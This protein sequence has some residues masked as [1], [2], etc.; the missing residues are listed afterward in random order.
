MSCWGGAGAP[1]CRRADVDPCR[2]LAPCVEMRVGTPGTPDWRSEFESHDPLAGVHASAA[3]TGYPGAT[4]ESNPVKRSL[5]HPAVPLIDLFA[6]PGGLCEGFSPLNGSAP[7]RFRSVLSIEM[8]ETAHRTLQLRAFLRRFAPRPIP[9]AYYQYLREE[10]SLEDLYLA[11]PAEAEAASRDAWRAEL[12][13]VPAKHVRRRIAHA[14]GGSENWV[15]LGGPPCQPFS[16]AGR[17]RNRSGTRYSDGQETRHRLYLEYLQI[18]ADFWPPV[19]VMENVRGLLSASY[20]GRRMFTRIQE[21]LRDPVRAISRENGRGLR[22]SGRSHTYELYPIS[23]PSADSLIGDGDFVV[24]CEDHGVPQARHRII[25]LG[26]RND[27]GVRPKHLLPDEPVPLRTVLDAM[28]RLRSGLS[29]G[30]EP[31]AWVSVVSS[32]R[33]QPWLRRLSDSDPAVAS[34]IVKA[35]SRIEASTLTRGA[36]FVALTRHIKGHSLGQW[37]EDPRLDGVPNHS[38]RGH[39]PED[40]HRYLFAASFARVHGISPTLHEFPQELLPRHRNAL[41]GH[42]ETPFADRFR[43][44]IRDRPG[45]TVVSHISKDGHYYIHPDPSQCRSLT[46]REA[47][48]IQTFPDNYRFVGNRTAQYTQVGNAVPPWLARQIAVIVQDVLA[49]SASPKELLWTG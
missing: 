10:I 35:V 6:G 21:D 40:L 45:T 28:P 46:V 8:E 42:A 4:S 25:I 5:D 26:V 13:V 31:D 1:R 24:R 37:I 47:A 12:G 2:G 15:L 19:F 34:T 43:V 44:Q 36:E 27:L 18:I 33:R 11:H 17:S 14:L 30:D 48:R 38:T 32:V 41:N 49:R 22:R 16:I 9:H 23:A 29:R 39:I 7:R 3:R 20:E